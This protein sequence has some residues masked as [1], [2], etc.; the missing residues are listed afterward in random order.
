MKYTG[1]E[2]EQ[3]AVFRQVRVGIATRIDTFLARE[4]DESPE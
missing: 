4:N 2:E 3:L 1:S